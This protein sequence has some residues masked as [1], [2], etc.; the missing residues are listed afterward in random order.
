MIIRDN[1]TAEYA[2]IA[3][4]QII[5]VCYFGNGISITLDTGYNVYLE[6]F[7][8]EE[9]NAKKDEKEE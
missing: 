4:G 5:S 1:R 7:E 9:I 3:E 2:K 8:L 6:D